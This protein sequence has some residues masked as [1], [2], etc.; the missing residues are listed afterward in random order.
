MKAIGVSY[1]VPW[2]EYYV[3]F[4]DLD[5]H[6]PLIF[7]YVKDHVEQHYYDYL[8]Y[9]TKHGYHFIG[10]QIGLKS[11]VA[12]AHDGVRFFT[13]SIN[14]VLRV[15]PNDDFK[16]IA[17]GKAWDKHSLR[18]WLELKYLYYLIFSKKGYKIPKPKGESYGSPLF[19]YYPMK[20]T[21]TEEWVEP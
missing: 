4:Y 18:S 13:D 10:F 19:A 3:F 1:Y 8:I 14:H 16:L 2:T 11:S 17:L 20:M 5:T 15:F 7:E 12:E 21:I 9:K 6:D